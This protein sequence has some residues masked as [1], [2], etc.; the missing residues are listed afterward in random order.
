MLRFIWAYLIYTWGGLHRYFG[1]QNHMR[2]EHEL[3]VRYFGKALYVAPDF[4]QAR[5][6]R[7]VLLG[8][9]LGRF[10]EALADF[11]YVLRDEPESGEAL[12]NRGLVLQQ[13]G[14]YAD[15][16]TDLE[17]YLA[18]PDSDSHLGEAQRIVQ[19]LREM[20]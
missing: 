16:L 18:L 10:A 1:N 8:R 11:D 12:L 6:A 5:L 19:I 7:G 9:E 4:Q 2:S 13:N 20:V 17:A 15:A 3:A 14:R